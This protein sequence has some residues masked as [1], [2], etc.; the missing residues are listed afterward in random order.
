MSAPLIDWPLEGTHRIEASAGTGKTFALALLH[1]RLVVERELPVR[2]ILAVTYTIAAT[3]ELRERLR[4]Q[5][6]RA[7]ELALFDRDVLR[8]KSA[9][10]DAEA[11]T[12]AV[13]ERRLQHEKADAL[14]TRADSSSVDDA[15]VQPSQLLGR[16][17]RFTKGPVSYR[18]D[19]SLIAFLSRVGREPW[20]QLMTAAR[21]G[22]D[23]LRQR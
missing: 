15:P 12:A 17:V 9:G 5:L 6:A 2:G 3:Q 11:I 16:A 22:R 18:L 20:A 14:A 8:A 1:T 19:G 13:L 4:R 21:W 23:R 7:A 10:T